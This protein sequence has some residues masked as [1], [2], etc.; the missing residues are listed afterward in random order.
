[1]EN[2]FTHFTY[3]H[4]SRNSYSWAEWFPNIF[5]FVFCFLSKKKQK[6]VTLLFIFLSTWSILCSYVYYI[7]FEPAFLSNLD[8]VKWN[9]G[10]DWMHRQISTFLYLKKDPAEKRKVLCIFMVSSSCIC[11]LLCVYPLMNR[12]DCL[13]SLFLSKYVRSRLVI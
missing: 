5:F 13:S 2:H 10:Y 8:Y 1:M 6:F 3:F 9:Q 11:Q 4:I 7:F 12:I